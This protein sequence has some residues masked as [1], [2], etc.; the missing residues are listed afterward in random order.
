M[1]QHVHGRGRGNARLLCLNH[2]EVEVIS[3]AQRRA[4]RKIEGASQAFLKVVAARWCKRL[5]HSAPDWSLWY[6]QRDR[7]C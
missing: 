6:L 5:E 1:L 2:A 7:Q 4:V 3:G